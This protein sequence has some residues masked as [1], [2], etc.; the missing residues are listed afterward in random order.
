VIHPPSLAQQLGVDATIA[1]GRPAQ[2]DLMH[3]ATQIQVGFT[4]LLLSQ[5]TVVSGPA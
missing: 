3:V 5:E 4:G 2:R 1:V